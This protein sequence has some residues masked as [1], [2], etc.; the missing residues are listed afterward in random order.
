MRF[1]VIGGL[2]L[3]AATMFFGGWSLR[4]ALERDQYPRWYI[5]RSPEAVTQWRINSLV[6]A[7]LMLV[8]SA[9]L[10]TAATI[11]ALVRFVTWIT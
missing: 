3:C 1:S 5:D 11:G 9:T 4:S 2:Y 7:R 6:C 8:V 10:A